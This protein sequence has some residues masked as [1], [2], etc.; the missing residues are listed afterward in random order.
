MIRMSFTNIIPAA[1]IVLLASCSNNTTVKDTP[2]TT[3]GSVKFD[4]EL[5][6]K[7]GADEYGMKKY[8][9]AFLYR[10]PN[11]DIPAD[12]ASALQMAHL[13][14]ITRMAEEGKLVLAGP[15]FGNGDLRGIYV[16]N[17]ESIEEAE[18]LTHSDPAI[19]AGSLR[20]ELMEWYGTAGLMAINEI[21][22]KLA[23]K[24]I[25]E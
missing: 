20:M 3:S 24:S 15:F 4:K 5:A 16:F 19:Q 8:I 2:G 1:L 14:N 9:F 21:S 6:G 25:I 17:V 22:E 12:S 7:Y 18:K 10:G 11:R 23:E 13:R